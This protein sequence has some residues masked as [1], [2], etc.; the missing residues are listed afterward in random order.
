[1]R[2]G[3]IMKTLYLTITVLM[4]TGFFSNNLYAK[5]LKDISAIGSCFNKKKRSAKKCAKANAKRSIIKK[6]NGKITGLKIK[7]SGRD[8]EYSSVWPNNF[9]GYIY[10][11]TAYGKCKSSDQPPVQ[12]PKPVTTI[13]TDQIITN[14]SD[15][16]VEE[17]YDC[18][19]KGA[20]GFKYVVKQFIKT[21]NN[22]SGIEKDF[23]K[24]SENKFWNIIKVADPY[25]TNLLEKLMK[26]CKSIRENFIT[27]LN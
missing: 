26:K 3:E 19:G 15:C 16:Y 5:N 1:M 14:A 4:I 7:Y 6:C 12:T 2:K 25:D 8:L 17:T 9:A 23:T 24:I 10:T 20:I 27:N 13:V 22:E 18:L 21:I 11:Y